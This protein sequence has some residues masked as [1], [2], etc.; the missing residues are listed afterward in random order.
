MSKGKVAAR[1][2]DYISERGIKQ[3]AIANATGMTPQAISETMKGNR[4]LTADEYGDIC[5]FLR[6]PYDQFFDPITETEVA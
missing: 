3:K 5:A 1:M 6:V 4:S 2:A